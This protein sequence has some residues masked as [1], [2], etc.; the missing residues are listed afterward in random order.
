MWNILIILGN[1]RLGYLATTGFAVVLACAEAFVHP[2]LIKRIFDVATARSSLSDVLYLGFGYLAFGLIVTQ[3]SLAGTL[4]NAR[5]DNRIV[6]DVSTKLMSAFYERSYSR[7]IADG[8]GYYIARIRSDVKDGLVPLLSL[9][10]GLVTNIATFLSLVTVLLI[11]SPS[12]FA[13]LVVIIPIAAFVSVT[14]SKRIQH[15]TK[16]ER[17][18]EAVLTDWLSRAVASFKIVTVFGLKSKVVEAVHGRTLNVLD[19]VYKRTRVIGF[20]RTSGDVVM[21]MSDASSIIVGSYLVLIGRMTIGSFIAFMNAFWRSS[22]TLMGIFKQLADWNSYSAILARI[23]DFSTEDLAGRRVAPSN[24]LVVNCISFKYGDTEVFR[25]ISF[26]LA[27][28]DRA[29]ILGPNGSGKSTLANL[30]AGNLDSTDGVIDI[31]AR[32]RAVTLP[33]RLPPLD[34]SELGIDPKLLHAFGL[35]Q[36]LTTGISLERMSAGQQQKVAI[37][38]ALSDSADLF[39]LDEP[40]ANLDDASRDVVMREIDRR[41]GSAILIVVMHDAE[42]YA[43]YFN[44]T[45]YL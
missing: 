6:G 18:G 19:A 23:V 11:I 43:K 10:R 17:D 27:A 15:I 29:L 28:G 20:L 32:V 4:W 21:V 13:M 37:A 5:V 3:L 16:T 9:T 1:H 35:S 42:R 31:P 2:L 8:D 41:T 14:V 26:A 40:L 12:A 45:I 33:V 38:L 24:R 25:D 44:E 34:L 22:T 30:I 39:V 7:I 36:V